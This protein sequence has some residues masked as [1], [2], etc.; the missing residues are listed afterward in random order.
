[1]SPVLKRKREKFHLPNK[2]LL[3]LLTLFCVGM[4][5]LSFTTN[6]LAAPLNYISS[7]LIVPFEKGLTSVGTYALEKTKQ[8]Q[9]LSYVLKENEQLKEHINELTIEN[10]LLQQEKYELTKLREL[11]ELDA[12]YENYNKIGAHII[13]RDSSNWYSS[14]VIDKG[15]DDGIKVNCNV[16]AGSGLVGR[17]VEVGPN[18]AK[19][20][21]IISDGINTSGM[22]LA[23]GDNLIV[24]G[25]LT[26]MAE[27]KIEYS[28]LID[29][30]NKVTV[31]D[32]IVTSN[33]S[34]Q[35]LPGILIGYISSIATDSNNLT[36][37]GYVTP[38]VDFEHLNEV[39]VIKELKQLP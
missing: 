15:S 14:F 27:G 25:N 21:S 31:G 35:Y 20:I 23:S 9:E 2:Y 30:K 18:H 32:K 39:L 24:T 17:V 5:I 10:T 38:V 6:F 33:I 1:M 28:Q 11:Y 36:K 29:S 7:Y 4:M 26:T 34:D 3:F 16:I 37:S 12:E 8:L 13:S 22:I 19:V